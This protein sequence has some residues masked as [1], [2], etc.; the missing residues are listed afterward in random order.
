MIAVVR[1]EQAVPLRK[2]RVRARRF[3]SP[4]KVLGSV[5]L[6]DVAQ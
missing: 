6:A 2:A 5:S 3:S 4:Q 1:C